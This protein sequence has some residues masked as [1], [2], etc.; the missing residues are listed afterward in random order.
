MGLEPTT[1]CMASA[2]DVRTRSRAFAQT[3]WLRRVSQGERTRPNPSE[4]RTLPSL[5]RSQ[6]PIGTR[7]AS[8]QADHGPC[9]ARLPGGGV[10]QLVSFA[11]T[12]RRLE[13][14]AR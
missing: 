9:S 7:R 8:L 4:R 2:S 10:S 12:P 13:T 6:A 14:C 3:A 1:F 5:P 11:V